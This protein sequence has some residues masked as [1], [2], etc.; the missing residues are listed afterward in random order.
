MTVKQ[1]NK[2]LAEMTDEVGALVL[3]NNYAQNVALANAVA[4]APSL[5]HAHQ[6]FMRRLE[7][8]GHARPGAGVPA[9][10]TGRSASGS[11]AGTGPDPARAGRPARLHQDHGG[12]RA[13]RA[14][15]CPTT[16]TCSGCCTPTSRRRCASGSPSTIDGHALRREIITTVLV[17]DTV[18]T[19]GSTFLHRLR[20]ETGRL[21]RGDRA[22]ADRGP[23]DLRAR[24]GLG[25]GRG[26]G[27]QGRGRRP[28]PDPAALAAARRARHALAA[29]QPAAAAAARRDHRASSRER[30]RRRSGPSCPS[31]CAARDLEWYQRILDELTARG[32]PGRAGRAGGRA[33]PPPSRRWTS[34]R[35]RTARA[36]TRWTSPRSTTTSP[37]G[38]GIT[39]LMDRIIELPRADRWQ[40]MARASIREDLYAAHAALTADVLSV[41][42]GTLDA[43]AALQGVGGE[44][45]GDPRPGAHHA[46]GDPGRR[47][48]STWRTC[49]WRCGRCGRCCAATADARGAAAGPRKRLTAAAPL[50]ARRHVGHGGPVRVTRTGPPYVCPLPGPAPLPAGG[51]TRSAVSRAPRARRRSLVEGCPVKGRLM[52]D[53]SNAVLAR[54]PAVGPGGE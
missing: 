24:R 5:L 25:R 38:C 12:R 17:N 27:Q 9:R 14:P 34:S 39:Q 20:E 19:G 53:S 47:R 11:T 37:T 46:G 6:R 48:P 54:P 31:C 23:R 32:R 44:E 49:R 8:D 52:P 35:S 15:S 33:S 26:A 13:D 3:R 4:Q 18:N 30:R 51:G 43:G 16:R 7:R 10:P 22:G 2:L 36:R 42:N 40:S 45:R 1:R 50:H 21:D 29:Q 41:G 28:D